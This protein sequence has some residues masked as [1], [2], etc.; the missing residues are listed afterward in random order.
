MLAALPAI[1][2][3]TRH[4]ILMLTC[5]ACV[6][7][8][9]YHT[10][11]THVSDGEDEAN[12]KHKPRV[13]SIQVPTWQNKAPF[14]CHTAFR[15]GNHLAHLFPSRCL[16]NLPKKRHH[17]TTALLKAGEA[18][19]LRLLRAMYWVSVRDCTEQVW[20]ARPRVAGAAMARNGGCVS[21][22]RC[23]EEH[24]WKRQ[25]YR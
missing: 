25:R 14:L 5:K 23:E 20:D 10:T 15:E 19:S 13:F 17:R 21:K 4:H 6:L 18:G 24:E 16:C 11:W 12:T 2:S 3:L 8:G 7:P 22:Q 9:G 1:R